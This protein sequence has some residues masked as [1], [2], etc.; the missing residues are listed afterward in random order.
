MSALAIVLGFT[1]GVEKIRS[2]LNLLAN[3]VAEPPKEA[4]CLGVSLAGEV[5][6]VLLLRFLG[7]E[8]TSDEP[9]DAFDRVIERSQ[10]RLDRRRL[11]IGS[12]RRVVEFGGN[13]FVVGSLFV[14]DGRK[15]VGCLSVFLIVG[16][17]GE[18]FVG[19]ILGDGGRPQDGIRVKLAIRLSL[20]RSR[21]AKQRE[22]RLACLTNAVTEIAVCHTC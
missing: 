1:D 11:A 21:G 2:R 14:G 12:P 5:A 19:G 10:H 6:R 16:P 20:E 13:C 17:G 9:A 7:D 22:C 18:G 15:A 3:V 4:G 8:T